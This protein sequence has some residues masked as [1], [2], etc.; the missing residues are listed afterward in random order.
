MNFSPTVVSPNIDLLLIAARRHDPGSVEELFVETV[1]ASKKNPGWH[2][3]LWELRLTQVRAELA[4]AREEWEA[5][6]AAADEAID[7]CRRRTRPKY[8]ALG[9]VTR[10]QALARLDRHADAIAAAGEA[11]RIARAIEDPALVLRALDTLLQL[12]GDD[13]TALEARTT[14]AQIRA[15]LSDETMRRRFDQSGMASRIAKL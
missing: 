2:G 12:E 5:A 14:C 1:E 13:A 11:V 10:A 9:Q 8:E 15:A 6:V 3:W 7:Q 4:F